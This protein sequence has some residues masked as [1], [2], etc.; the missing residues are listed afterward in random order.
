MLNDNKLVYEE[1]AA[2]KIGKSKLQIE[3]EMH[4]LLTGKSS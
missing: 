3:F 2:S 4:N 1:K